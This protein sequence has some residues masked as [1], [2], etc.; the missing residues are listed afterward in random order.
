MFVRKSPPS[1]PWRVAAA[2]VVECIA[3]VGLDDDRPAR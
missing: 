2:S 1:R 3:L